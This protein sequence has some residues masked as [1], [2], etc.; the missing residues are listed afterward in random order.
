VI[1]AKKSWWILALYYLARP[2]KRIVLQN[3]IYAKSA[4]RHYQDFSQ[5]EN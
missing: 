5:K 4:S 3:T 1:N 2:T